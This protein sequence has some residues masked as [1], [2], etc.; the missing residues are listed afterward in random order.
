MAPLS[1]C[2]ELRWQVANRYE[3][4][5]AVAMMRGGRLGRSPARN[6]IDRQI[7]DKVAT[8]RFVTE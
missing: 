7:Y 3:L 5:E 4:Y 2:S 6:L 8:L 1:N